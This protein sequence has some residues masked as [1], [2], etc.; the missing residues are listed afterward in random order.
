[1]H[2]G[3][4]KVAE[5]VNCFTLGHILHFIIITIAIAT[6]SGISIA[7]Q[8]CRTKAWHCA[9]TWRSECVRCLRRGMHGAW[10]IE[11]T[12]RSCTAFLSSMRFIETPQS[13]PLKLLIAPSRWA[14]IAWLTSRKNPESEMIKIK[15]LN[16]NY[17]AVMITYILIKR[18][19]NSRLLYL[20]Y[21]SW[22]RTVRNC[23]RS[24]NNDSILVY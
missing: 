11:Y 17:N 3:S 9:E 2:C 13:R 19:T 14:N 24:C 6:F 21:S 16:G 7:V 18:Y 10:W 4:T 5:L 20:L 22:T 23:L 15:S 1:M 8:H 12:P